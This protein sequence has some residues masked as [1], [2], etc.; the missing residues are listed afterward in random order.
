MIRTRLLSAVLSIFTLL[1]VYTVAYCAETNGEEYLSGETEDI[2]AD[3]P[4]V[5]SMDFVNYHDG[6]VNNRDT[7][8][9][10]TAEKD[11]RVTVK[12]VPNLNA[13]DSATTTVDGYH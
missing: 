11:G 1:S 4:D 9:L 2:A 10:E 6:I 7:G 8:Y 13:K 3:Y 12:A 5:V